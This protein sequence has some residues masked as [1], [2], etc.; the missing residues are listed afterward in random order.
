MTTDTAHFF[1]DHPRNFGAR[2]ST[3]EKIAAAI[4]VIL[5]SRRRPRPLLLFPLL[6][7]A[8]HR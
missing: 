2:L 3:A 5:P 1:A 4:S 6:D 8:T 7:R